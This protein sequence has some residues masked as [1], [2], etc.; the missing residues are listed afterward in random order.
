MIVSRTPLSLLERLREHP[1]QEAWQRFLD[2][3]TPMIED[4][5]RRYAVQFADIDD[6]VQDIMLVLMRE[7]PNFRHNERD[8]AFRH[9]LRQIT[10][11]RSRDFWRA[12]QSRPAVLGG[13]DFAAMLDQLA[14]PSS[15]LSQQWD[16]EYNRHIVTR[17]LAA[18]EPD[19]TPGT[20]QAFRRTVLDGIK[21][22]GA[23]A[24]LGLSVNAV[25]I[26]KSRVLSRLRT[27]LRGL[28]E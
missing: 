22:A 19:F 27:E 28:L 14:D 6:L 21:P 2:L 4:W 10:V 18:V 3:Y 1:D 15:D 25:L 8:G 9:W 26:A 7:L 12:Q 23:A 13:S 11:H 5:L 16:R 17:L 24:E 20:W